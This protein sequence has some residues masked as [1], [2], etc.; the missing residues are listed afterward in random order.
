[1]RKTKVVSCVLLIG[2]VL[3]AGSASIAA[4]VSESK[5]RERV[6]RVIETPPERLPSEVARQL[7][8]AR[9]RLLIDAERLTWKNQQLRW[10]LGRRRKMSSEE[11]LAALQALDGV[12]RYALGEATGRDNAPLFAEAEAN[13]LVDRSELS[14]APQPHAW[15]L[16]QDDVE[17]AIRRALQDARLSATLNAARRNFD[18]PER[19][20]R[21]WGMQ[22]VEGVL[23]WEL[24]SKDLNDEPPR[25]RTPLGYR[26]I[27]KQLEEQA[28]KHK[29]ML[30]PHVPA[31]RSFVVAALSELTDPEL[32]VPLLDPQDANALP[33]RIVAAELR[34][35]GAPPG[36]MGV[37]LV[38]SSPSRGAVLRTLSAMALEPIYE[39]ELWLP[40]LDF[41]RVGNF[42]V[43]GPPRLMVDTGGFSG[44][45]VNKVAF[46][47]DG[48]YLAA[49]GDVVRIW[50]LENGQLLH[51]LRGQRS[52]DATGGCTDLAFTP[53]GQQLLVAAAGFDDSLRVYDVAAPQQPR[54]VHGGH[55]GHIERLAISRDGQWL[56]THGRD[57]RLQIWNWPT[58]EIVATFPTA[59]A[60]DHLSFPSGKANVFALAGNGNYEWMHLPDGLKIR[61]EDRTVLESRLVHSRTFPFG[62]H[63]HPFAMDL[64]WNEEQWLIAGYSRDESEKDHYWCGYWTGG[65]AEPQSFYETKY[66]ITACDL[67]SD[68]RWAATADALGKIAVW[69]T[70]NG[71][72]RHEFVSQVKPVYAV[73]YDQDLAR[74]G[75]GRVPYV[76]PEWGFNHYG[77][78][79]SSFDLRTRLLQDWRGDREPPA[80]I[81]RQAGYELRL[82]ISEGTQALVTRD[83]RGNVLATLPFSGSSRLLPLC[84]SFLKGSETGFHNCVAL[85]SED[86]SVVCLAPETLHSR[87]T[88]IG[89]SD[90][91]WTFSQ[92]ADERFLVSGGGDGTIRFWRL[93]PS[94]N[95]GNLAI[96]A[97]DDGK[98]HHVFPGTPTAKVIQKGDFIRQVAGQTLASLRQ[99]FAATQEWK[100]RAGDAVNVQIQR[101]QQVFD[102]KV[103][104]SPA[105]DVAQPLLSL[106]ITADGRDW[107]LWTPEGYY[108]AS[109]SGAR[110]VGWHV[111]RG[112]TKSAEF[113][114][115]ERFSERFY[116]PDVIDKVLEAGDVQEALRLAERPVN[117]AVA[118]PP[119]PL[120]IEQ[121]MPPSVE[122]QQPAPST[123]TGHAEIEVV[124]RIRSSSPPERISVIVNG[125]VRTANDVTL[126]PLVQPRQGRFDRPASSEREYE[127]RQTVPLSAGDNQI[128]LVVVNENALSHSVT[129]DVRYRETVAPPPK[130]RLVVGAVG[131]SKYQANDYNL[132]FADADAKAFV[133]SWRVAVQSVKLALR[134]C[135]GCGNGS[136]WMRNNSGKMFGRG[137]LLRSGWW[138]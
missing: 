88:F 26:Q 101:G 57:G 4:E 89:H 38:N 62:G 126:Q 11:H 36:A 107:V 108:D 110:Y 79:E 12:L 47:P 102:R 78:L 77:D 2:I 70:R 85:G 118:A 55:D 52:W 16:T 60:I 73:R 96:L 59:D 31:L 127:Y 86:G 27:V 99:E 51:T 35:A 95:W 125:V 22:F 34:V 116:R 10:S 40:E 111:N 24:P 54:E 137:G 131:I 7:E 92:S 43:D 129:V 87:R 134:G 63:P 5:L 14:F 28:R 17:G 84:C 67:S 128:K 68:G 97:D 123:I 136:A 66:Y 115:L 46:S 50:D 25:L 117:V 32:G 100:H 33:I 90:R 133:G 53:D 39:K 65:I 81:E 44:A 20:E 18:I 71:D 114:P 75:F 120:R 1:M 103:A 61:V 80:A 112:V 19:N 105:G 113:Y 29:K 121:A 72:V 15:E 58:R 122:I 6:A 45:V 93:S 69:D 130:K 135:G 94:K 64:D 74:I 82:L 91:V 23:T 30:Q 132:D 56:A 109:P 106:F 119:A 42:P 21:F 83:E 49:A 124:A 13:G 48:R 3:A 37:P 9:E 41:M 98:V 8:L 76:T 138:I 104:L